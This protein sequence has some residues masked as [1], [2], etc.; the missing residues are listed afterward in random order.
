MT[1]NNNILLIVRQSNGMDYNDLYSKIMPQY[2][3]AASAKSALSRALKDLVAFGLV[4][5][6]GSKVFITDKGTASISIEMKEKL[7]LK[8]NDDM[9]KPMQNL[10]DI[11]RLLAVLNQRGSQH[12]DML[13]NAKESATFTIHDLQMIRKK[14]REE[15]KSLKRMSELLDTQA[16]RLEE[17]DFNDSSEVPFDS[18]LAAKIRG[19]AGAQKVVAELRDE[20]LLSKVPD[21]WKRQSSI[22]VEGDQLSMLLQLMLSSPSLKA[23]LYL[24][25]VK[26]SVFSGKAMCLGSAKTLLAFLGEKKS[27]EPAALAPQSALPQQPFA[28]TSAPQA[29]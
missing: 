18:A 23:N 9:R 21:A 29:K 3:N 8:L 22:S 6:E 13:K 19:F 15:R 11:V 24:P 26:I 5:R 20:E 2:K 4:K 10:G 16:K 27:E 7:V 17:L 25:G 28:G 12:P 14:I 1:F